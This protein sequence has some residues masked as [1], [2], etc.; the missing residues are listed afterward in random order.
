MSS[1]DLKLFR[2]EIKSLFA[3]T[4]EK[5]ESF[6]TTIKT[7]IG[8]IRSELLEHK[9]R[10]DKT[11]IKTNNNSEKIDELTLQIEHPKQDRIK[12]NI[13]LTGLPPQA[14]DDP[15]DTILRIDNILNTEL[16]PSD[17]TVH[18]DRNK[19]SLIISFSSYALKRFFMDR[20]RQKQ[21]LFIEEI[22]DSIKSNSQVYVNDQLTPYFAQLFQRAWRAKKD[23]HIHSAS[24][25]GGRIRVK[26]HENG[27]SHII[28]NETQ[29]KEIISSN[30]EQMDTQH[31]ENESQRSQPSKL[32]T[33]E[34]PSSVN[35]FEARNIR[36]K[37]FTHN[38]KS[39]ITNKPTKQQTSYKF[40]RIQNHQ[41]TTE[42]QYSREPQLP[43]SQKRNS[44][45]ITDLG[46]KNQQPLGKRSTKFNTSPDL[47]SRYRRNYQ[48]KLRSFTK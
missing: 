18:A 11:D 19:S 28:E 34:S 26:K 16:I 14:Y 42:N 6:H 31:I 40:R 25:V 29:L 46:H 4:N 1:E 27:Q 44:R 32:N 21:S 24:S 3:A 9:N 30:S 20:M 41:K 39:S 7:D 2:D 47:E 17:Y 15:D 45:H 43:L 38:R 22:Y 10:I 48:N 37:V 36:G 23:G 33:T 13:R 5:I 8:N 12:N 35:S